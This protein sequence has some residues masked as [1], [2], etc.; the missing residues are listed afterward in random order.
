MKKE[1][2]NIVNLSSALNKAERNARK[3]DSEKD[4]E[5]R[6]QIEE[7][8]QSLLGELENLTGEKHYIGTEKNPFAGEPFNQ[9]MHR[10]LD[11]LVQI[12]YLTT[13]EESFLFRIQPYLEF[14]SNVIIC[15]EDKFKKKKKNVVEDDF[16]LPKSATIS[17]IAEMLGR[18]REKTSKVMNSLKRKEILLNPEGA[19]HTIENGRTVS[20]RT[21]IVNPYIMICAPRK[22]DVQLDKL[23]MRLFQHSLKN[24]K[25]KDGK[26]V[27]LPVRFF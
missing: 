10:N 16:E 20:P 11:L 2:S 25:D 14:K 6:K 24:L 5:V 3:R 1:N 21:W 17:D 19:G 22:N 8:K 23:T 4:S 27:N 12:D 13:S 15:R 7:I 9:V 26:K 18:S